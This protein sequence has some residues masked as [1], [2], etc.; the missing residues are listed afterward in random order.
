MTT[1]QD[2]RAWLGPA[3]ETATAA[4]VEEICRAWDR[5]DELHDGWD[6][7]DPDRTES[8]TG[9]AMTI[10][11]DATLESLGQDVRNAQSRLDEGCGSRAGVLAAQA[12]LQGAMIVADHRGVPLSEIAR[13]SGAA[14]TTVYARLGR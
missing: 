3:N 4:Q 5:L 10:L 9:A 12:R 6:P 7:S 1:A 8:A 2:V 11:G 13:A 14:R